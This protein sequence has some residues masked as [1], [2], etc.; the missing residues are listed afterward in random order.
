MA[1]I[2][3]VCVDPRINHELVRVQV[4]SRLESLGLKAGRVF[5]TSDVGG[6]VGSAF[7]GTI[8]LVRADEGQVVFAAVVHHD[9]CIAARHNKRQPLATSLEAAQKAL[10]SAGMHCSIVAGFLRTND[11]TLTWSGQ[12]ARAYKVFNFRMP[13]L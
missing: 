3:N 6:N 4:Q 13:R 11:S 10:E 2:V 7:T 12:P 1:A 5:I 9:D 8:D